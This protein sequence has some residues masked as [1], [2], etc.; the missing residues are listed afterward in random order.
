MDPKLLSLAQSY[1]S[2]V[3]DEEIMLVSALASLPAPSHHE[4]K[5]AR[6]IVDWFHA[7]GAPEA[8]IDEQKNVIVPIATRNEDGTPRDLAVFAAH[9]DVVFPDRDSFHPEVS[10]TRIEAPGIGDDTA[11]LAGLMLAAR[12]LIQHPEITSHMDT[13]LL[14]VANS[15]EEGLGNLDGTKQVFNALGHR[16]HEY[17]S[18]DR[19]MPQCCS[20]AVGSRRF[21]I[22]CHARGGHSWA[23]YGTPNALER[24]CALVER[25]YALPLPE[26][27]RTTM[28]VGKIEGGTTVNSI[29]EDASLLFEFRST[30]E[31]VL[32]SLEK[33]L[34]QEVD[35]LQAPECTFSISII[36]NRPGNGEVPEEPEAELTQ[37]CVDVLTKIAGVR[38]DLSPASTDANI[39]L[40]MGI[41]ATSVGTIIGGGAHTREEWIDATSLPKGLAVTLSLMLRHARR[42]RDDIGKAQRP[43]VE[44]RIRK[45]HEHADALKD[46]PELARRLQDLREKAEAVRSDPVARAEIEAHIEAIRKRAEEA[47]LSHHKDQGQA[48]A[49]SAQ[50]DEPAKVR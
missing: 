24:I 10:G 15:C 25:L 48:T 43:E 13:G 22:S 7:N 37:A 46:D 11:C 27:P 35:K 12:Y 9:T 18:F 3:Y 44:E 2:S 34:R 19:Y 26:D 20:V 39:P 32:D 21:K 33:Q 40:S 31:E 36:G 41:P 38:P 14:V 16:I 45:L 23:D 17:I 30:S 5:R 6:F 4:G 28:N 49:A 47:R 50:A 8:Y 42:F 1:A 29:A